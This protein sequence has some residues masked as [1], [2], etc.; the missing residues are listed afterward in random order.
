MSWDTSFEGQYLAPSLGPG[1][2]VL[3]MCLAMG[4]FFVV[5]SDVIF[6]SASG[7]VHPIHCLTRGDV[8]LHMGGLQLGWLQ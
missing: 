1:G 6:A 8:A 2:R 7:V 4:I 3:R 5:R